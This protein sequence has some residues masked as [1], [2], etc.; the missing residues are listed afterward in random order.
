MKKYIL[1]IVYNEETDTVETLEERVDIK[2]E[3]PIAINASQE[4]M[5]KISAAGLIEPLLMGLPGECVGET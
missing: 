3:Q 4:V 1:T 5:E 2:E